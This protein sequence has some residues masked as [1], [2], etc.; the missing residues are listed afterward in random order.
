MLKKFCLVTGASTG[1]GRAIAIEFAGKGDDVALVGRNEKGLLET[2]RLV[3]TVGG[4]L[5]RNI[6]W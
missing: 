3:E 2:K 4:G 1:I 5:S 6:S